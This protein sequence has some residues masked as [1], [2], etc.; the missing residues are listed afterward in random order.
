M[1][2]RYNFIAEKVLN[3]DAC[4]FVLNS[5]IS[6]FSEIVPGFLDIIAKNSCFSTEHIKFMLE[7]KCFL[8]KDLTSILNEIIRKNAI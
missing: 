7:N 8:R 4:D 5:E 6:E 2:T 3:F 1:D